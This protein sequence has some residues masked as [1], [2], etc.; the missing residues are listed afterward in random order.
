[1]RQQRMGLI[2]QAYTYIPSKDI[3][4]KT[5]TSMTTRRASRL[6]SF[7]LGLVFGLGMI[8]LLAL[9]SVLL[10][11]STRATAMSVLSAEEFQVRSLSPGKVEEMGMSPG[12]VEDLFARL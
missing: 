3:L 7:V 9:L 10:S 4:Q 8:V 1:M 6:A 5:Q 2:T 12:L 11:P